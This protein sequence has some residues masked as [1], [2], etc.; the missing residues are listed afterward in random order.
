MSE[1][2]RLPEIKPVERRTFLRYSLI[3]STAAGLGAFGAGSWDSCGPTWVK[4]SVRRS[5]LATPRT[6]WPRSAPSAPLVNAAGRMYVVEYD[7]N[8]PGADQ[9]DGIGVPVGST[10][11]MALYHTCVHLG[12]RVPWCQ[13]SQYFECPCHGSKYNKWGEWVAGP[14]SRG[15]DRFVS[16]VDGD[17]NLQVATANIITGPARTA[18]V[19]AQEPEGPACVDL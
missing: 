9:Y 8:L 6:S 15:L 10:G 1:T 14:A 13:S 2:R 3:G 11:L 17:G 4:G 19:L 7:P 5:T 12:C 18:R 16:E